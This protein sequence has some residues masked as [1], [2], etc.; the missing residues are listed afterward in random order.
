VTKLAVDE[1]VIGFY[2]L[3]LRDGE[4]EVRSE[5]I[6]KLPEV[7]KYASS[8][9]LL[10]KILPILKEQMAKDTSQHVKGSM[11]SAICELALYIPKDDTVN[12]ILPTVVAIMKDSV[13]E[14]RVSLMQNI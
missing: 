12:F 5:A 14:V 3:L 11:A 2:E 7:S 1:D 4:P 13:T 6:S 10:D 8:H 9:V